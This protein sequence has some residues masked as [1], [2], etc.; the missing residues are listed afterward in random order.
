[1]APG[2]QDVPEA[3][4]PL[5][6]SDVT[7][8]W[9]IDELDALPAKHEHDLIHWNKHKGMFIENYDKKKQDAIMA[10]IHDLLKYG[11][12]VSY[13]KTFMWHILGMLP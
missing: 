6:L 5:Q 10:P 8:R 7:L 2:K 11:G 1:M 9:M 12:G 3:D 4:D 13:V